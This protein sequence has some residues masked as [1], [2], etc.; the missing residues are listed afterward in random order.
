VAGL[1]PS[2]IDYVNAPVSTWSPGQPNHGFSTRG[3]GS[4]I[5]CAE[6]LE[7]RQKEQ[8]T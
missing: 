4:M 5:R 6:I 7:V 1:A 2:D 8:V 3:D